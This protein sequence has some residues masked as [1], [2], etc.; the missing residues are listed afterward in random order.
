MVSVMRRVSAISAGPRSASPRGRRARSFCGF[1]GLSAM[2]RVGTSRDAMRQPGLATPS[3]ALAGEGGGEGKPQARCPFTPTPTLPRK[4]EREQLST[5]AC[6]GC[7]RNTPP[8]SQHL[9]DPVVRVGDAAVLDVDEL[10]A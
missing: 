2:A 5:R 1:L 10:L 3:P 8:H 7:G 6:R 4:R 9:F